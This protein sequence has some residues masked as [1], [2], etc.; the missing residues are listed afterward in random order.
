MADSGGR[1]IFF[2]GYCGLCNGFVDFVIAR[3][4]K[5]VFRFAPLQGETANARIPDDAVPPIPLGSAGEPRTLVFRE[6]GRIY[7]RSDAVL[8]ALPLLGGV[9]K[10]AVLL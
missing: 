6:N 9:W 4:S 8:R 10:L 7:R 2:D 5:A 1:I 3:D